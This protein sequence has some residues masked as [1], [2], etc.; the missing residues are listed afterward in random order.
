M[1]KFLAIVRKE[2]LLLLR[3]VAG[4]I[5]LFLMPMV[6]IVIMSLMQEDGWN[7]VA[8]DRHV[9]VL[10]VDN[11]HDSLGTMIN[12]GLKDSH[13]LK[14]MDSLDGKPLTVNIV[15]EA[16]KSGKFQ[17]GI[18]IPKGV[19][20]S[21]RSNV[22]LTV[23]KT[24]AGFGFFNL[25]LVNDI[26]MK[27]S[28]TISIYFDPAV[29]PSFKNTIVSSIKEN[30]YRI[31]TEMVFR[32]FNQEM[33]KQFPNFKPPEIEYKEGLVFK[34]VYASDNHEEKVPNTVQ[35]NVPAW[36]V[37][38]MFFIIIPLTGSMI[39]EREE[40]SLFR[41]LTMPVAYMEL[42]LAKVT[43]Y[44]VV[45][46]IQFGL[47]IFSGMY[48]LPLFHIP[49]LVLGNSYTALILLTILT[50]LSALGYGLLVGTVANT[51]Q[52]AASFGAVSIIILAALGGLWVPTYIMPEFMTHVAVFSP[53]NWSITGYYNIFLRGGDLV[54]ILPQSI[55]LFSFFMITVIGTYLYRKIKSPLNQ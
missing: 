24:L 33:A 31:E 5:I 44:F 7:A 41:L 3:D 1:F 40:G 23:A 51:H 53:L 15:R 12:R 22:R 35:H 16:V 27:Q 38:A 13:F 19:T 20:K 26:R 21:I 47:M 28:D 50:A 17:I 48:I 55:K 34:E 49:M 39:K 54:N 42:L 43:V 14:L 45:C 11:D 6:L 25:S 18:I 46:M 10:F 36:T 9:P 4:L 8:K 2:S 32:T 52:Q 29:K 30:N 37:F